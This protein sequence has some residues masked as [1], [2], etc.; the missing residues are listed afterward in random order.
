MAHPQNNFTSQFQSDGQTGNA[1]LTL[2]VNGENHVYTPQGNDQ[3]VSVA[4]PVV[5]EMSD[6][7]TYSEIN[8]VLGQ[9]VPCFLHISGTGTDYML[10]YVGQSG[11]PDSLYFAACDAQNTSVIWYICHRGSSWTYGRSP[12]NMSIDATISGG[13]VTSATTWE[14]VDTA[15]RVGSSIN[16]KASDGNIYHLVRV[17]NA[18]DNVYIFECDQAAYN[19]V[20]GDVESYSASFITCSRDE[21]NSTIWRLDA[22]QSFTSDERKTYVKAYVDKLLMTK[23]TQLGWAAVS[24]PGGTTYIKVCE[25]GS[26]GSP[27]IRFHTKFSVAVYRDMYTGGDL[28]YCL[29]SGTFEIGVYQYAGANSYARW[30]EYKS[31]DNHMSWTGVEEAIVT[32]TPDGHLKTEV[33]L[34]ITGK[35][36][37]FIKAIANASSA[38]GSIPFVYPN[39]VV[40]SSATPYDPTLTI[41]EYPTVTSQDTVTVTIGDNSTGDFVQGPARMYTALTAA[42]SEG[43]LITVYD[44]RPGSNYP[45]SRYVITDKSGNNFIGIANTSDYGLCAI[46]LAYS[47]GAWTITRSV[48]VINEAISRYVF[49]TS[50]REIS[51]LAFDKRAQFFTNLKNAI[52]DNVSV[53][54]FKEDP[55]NINVVRHY[56]YTNYFENGDVTIFN[57]SNTAPINGTTMGMEM[58]HVSYD[59]NANTVTTTTGTYKWSY[60]T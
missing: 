43:K 8:E 15:Y 25:I 14:Q 40:E 1:V 56:I 48:N 13:T 49:S 23:Q 26:A 29:E 47:G 44:N 5:F 60:S 38:D 42:W 52:N 57:F 22:Y 36:H 31:D 37:L 27:S 4:E 45:V 2:S 51:H 58:V 10:P 21:D 55:S 17:I 24:C 6:N 7:P 18:G 12:Y 46:K 34:K 53:V 32:N 54:Y 9:H 33:W 50:H 30:T 3:T 35:C 59:S 19:N 39:A 41:Y 20:R 11:D 16:I 28:P